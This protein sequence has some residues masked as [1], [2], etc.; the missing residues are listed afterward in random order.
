MDLNEKNGQPS[1]EEILASIRRIIAEEPTSAN[2][3]I[4]LHA[5]Y[6]ARGADDVES[7]DFEL[8][9][10]FR[11][12]GPAAA[13]RQ[14]L[15]GRLTDA[16]RNAGSSQESRILRPNGVTGREALEADAPEQRY[17]GALRDSGSVLAFVAQPSANGAASNG[18]ASGADRYRGALRDSG[19][20]SLTSALSS[21]KLTR[22][23]LPTSA[24]NGEPAEPAPPVEAAS[25]PAQPAAASAEPVHDVRRVMVPFRDMR[26]ARM[27]SGGGPSAPLIESPSLESMTA[28]MPAEAFTPQYEAPVEPAVQPVYAA[29]PIPPVA[30][31]PFGYDEGL[32]LNDMHRVAPVVDRSPPPPPPPPHQPVPAAAAQGGIEDTTA[33]LLRPMLRQWLAENMPRMVEKALSIELAQSVKVNRKFP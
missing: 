16:I 22:G 28:A 27:G 2:P 20:Q 30:T 29:P 7:N 21:L 31:N 19:A 9:S 13:E 3:V 12:N 18:D 23:E 8:P 24:L 4:D 1:M 14:P 26:M 15:F 33:D 32:S 10:I 5:K 6:K 25:A 17:A 11:P